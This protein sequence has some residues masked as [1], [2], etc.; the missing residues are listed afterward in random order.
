V[1]GY[2]CETDDDTHKVADA[3][4]DDPLEIV[5]RGCIFHR[6]LIDRVRHRWRQT[7]H[8]NTLQG[9]A[10]GLSGHPGRIHRS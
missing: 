6:G 8:R 5:V 9:Q 10:L 7:R 2:D 3:H 4:T 1:I